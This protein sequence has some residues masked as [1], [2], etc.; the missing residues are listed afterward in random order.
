MIFSKRPMNSVLYLIAVMFT[1]S[2]HYILLSA[3]FLAII[4]IIVYAGAI[5][6]LFLFLIMFLNIDGEELIQKT[7]MQQ[8]LYVLISGVL[9]VLTLYYYQVNL[10]TNT[11]S[12][13]ELPQ[14][15]GELT[16]LGRLLFSE[17]IFPFE[18]A[19]I[20]FLAAMVSVVN[21]GLKSKKR[22]VS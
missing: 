7:K 17:Y 14:N 19:S 21:M 16:S 3:P 11:I 22:I 4:N 8:M 2:G 13:I 1:L 5:M 20:L 15:F 10:T 18:I 9:L 6:V 12:N